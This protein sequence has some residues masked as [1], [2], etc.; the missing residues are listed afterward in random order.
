MMLFRELVRAA[1]DGLMLFFALPYI[2]T[3]GRKIV[4]L[5]FLM[6]AMQ[7]FATESATPLRSITSAMSKRE[8]FVF[9]PLF[10]GVFA[11]MAKN[12]VSVSKVA[13]IF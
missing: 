6:W 7:L 11:K 1:G 2:G 4:I 12:Q 10:A 3:A 5:A 8:A 9:K 13:S